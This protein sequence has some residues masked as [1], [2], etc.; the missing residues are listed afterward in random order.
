MREWYILDEGIH[1]GKWDSRISVLPSTAAAE[2]IWGEGR[3]IPLFNWP[4]VWLKG[5]I[6]D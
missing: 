1:S 3:T 4:E 2:G 5:I 6:I